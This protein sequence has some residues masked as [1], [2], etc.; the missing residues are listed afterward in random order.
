[1]PI[2]DSRITNLPAASAGAA[3][4]EFAIE[5]A[6]ASEKLTLAQ[7]G[8]VLIGSGAADDLVILDSAGKVIVADTG[9]ATYSSGRLFVPNLTVAVNVLLED[10][11]WITL[12]GAQGAKVLGSASSVVKIGPHD[13]NQTAQYWGGSIDFFDSGSGLLA[14]RMSS[15][16]WALGNLNSDVSSTLLIQDAMPVTGDTSVIIK[17][18]AVNALN[19]LEFQT[20]SGVP[21]WAFKSP[22]E[23]GAVVDAALFIKTIGGGG[24]AS[25]LIFLPSADITGASGAKSH[26][27]S[28][29]VFNPTSGTATFVDFAISSTIN[30]TGGANG[31]T[32]GLYINPIL[33]AAADFRALEVALGKSVFLGDVGIGT[34]NPAVPLH[35]FSATPVFRLQDSDD[36]GDAA[37]AFM[38]FYDTTVRLGWFGFGSSSNSNLT[39][40]NNVSGGHVRLDPGATADV[41]VVD[42]DIYTEGDGWQEFTSTVVGFTSTTIQEIWYKKVGKTV[43]VNF[44]INGTSNATTLSFTVPFLSVSTTD[45]QTRVAVRLADNGVFLAAPGMTFLDANSSTVLV[46]MDFLG[47][48]VF[49]A[50]GLKA[51]QGQMWY[52]T[53]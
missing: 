50:S 11:V 39:V 45:V 27:T 40:T 25:G 41:L 13:K 4:D 43:F 9:N 23:L 35:L 38:E 8:D 2:G 3:T 10:D 34:A 19:L 22:T 30:Q 28:S 15:G 53:P 1:M 48:A 46:F 51:V 18:G 32:R 31:I 20:N 21:G 7:I 29:P 47:A 14:G 26:L 37:S 36:A 5:K 52:Q 16:N 6:G 42:S 12:P 33:T 17:E 44:H 49:T 24:S